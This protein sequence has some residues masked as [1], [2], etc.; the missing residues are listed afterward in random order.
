MRDDEEQ[1]QKSSTWNKLGVGA[2]EEKWLEWREHKNVAAAA[3]P[4][5][6]PS[7]DAKSA[8]TKKNNSN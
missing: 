7:E 1:K 6:F 2:E 4:L 8:Q 3:T 5:L